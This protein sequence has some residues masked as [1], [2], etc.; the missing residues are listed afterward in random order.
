MDAVKEWGISL[1]IAIL[2]GAAVHMLSPSSSM[3]KIL[4]IVVSIFLISSMFYPLLQLNG[5][6]DLTLSEMS[7]GNMEEALG[8]VQEEVNRQMIQNT[9][10]T[11]A[12]LIRDQMT[13]FE[14]PPD[15][16]TVTADVDEEGNLFIQEIII[17]VPR[18]YISNK[19]A[20]TERIKQQLGFDCT[21]TEG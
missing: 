11:V 19:Y 15:E 1:C 12:R 10:N 3:Q 20:I 9:E 14:T 13:D 21:V 6:F 16:I 4:K 8:S 7:E 18:E 17:E 2:A 5:D